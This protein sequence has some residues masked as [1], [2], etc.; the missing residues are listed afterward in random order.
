MAE[1]KQKTLISLGFSK[2]V[3]HRGQWL[4]VSPSKTEEE[5]GF[6]IKCVASAKNVL[7]VSKDSACMSHGTT[8]ILREAERR[9]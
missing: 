2:R 1:K 8:M 3:L 4:P 7:K 5:N 9:N 6:K